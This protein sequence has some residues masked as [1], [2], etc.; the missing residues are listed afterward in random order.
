MAKPQVTMVRMTTGERTMLDGLAR[1]LDL[2]LNSIL[3]LALRRLYRQVN[4]ASLPP[5]D[6][7]Q[8]L[9]VQALKDE[10]K[11]KKGGK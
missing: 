8:D 10:S 11:Q 5:P 6:L 4:A 9:A 3:R 2:P 7:M 1:L